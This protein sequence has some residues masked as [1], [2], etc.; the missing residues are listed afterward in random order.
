LIAIVVT[1]VVAL[2]ALFRWA[3]ADAGVDAEAAKER[4]RAE[5][6]RRAMRRSGNDAASAVAHDRMQKVR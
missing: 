6:E 3:S 2:Y 5:Q 1:G 4:F